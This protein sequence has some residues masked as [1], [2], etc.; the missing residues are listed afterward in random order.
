MKKR[1]I[2]AVLIVLFVFSLLPVTVYAQGENGIIGEEL[3]SIVSKTPHAQIDDGTNEGVPPDDQ[4]DSNTTDED[5][6]SENPASGDPASEDPASEDPV[7][8]DPASEDPASEDPVS[9]EPTKLSDLASQEEIQPLGFFYNN[10][11]TWDE[12]ET[13]LADPTTGS[14]T[15]TGDLTVP[16]DS[17]ITLNT[18]TLNIAAGAALRI[19]NGKISVGQYSNIQISGVLEIGSS[20]TEGPFVTG[21]IVLYNSSININADGTVS[22]FQNGRLSLKNSSHAYILGTLFNN[23][24]ID[25]DSATITLNSYGKYIQA[26]EECRIHRSVYGTVTGIDNKYCSNS[27]VYNVRT[28]EEFLTS[29]QDSPNN[30]ETPYTINLFASITLI[31]TLDLAENVDVNIIKTDAV[32][33]SDGEIVVSTGCQLNVNG[34][35][36][37]DG[38]KLD[39]RGGT[40][41]IK[42]GSI[43]ATA[44]VLDT[45]TYEIASDDRDD[46]KE[47]ISSKTEN[48]DKSR[49]E[50]ILEETHERDTSEGRASTVTAMQD[51]S[52]QGLEASDSSAQGWVEVWDGGALEVSNGGTCK[53]FAEATLHIIQEAGTPAG[54][55]TISGT[56]SKLINYGT[57]YVYGGTLRLQAPAVYEEDPSSSNYLII[58]EDGTI[59]GISSTY[60]QNNHNIP[61]SSFTELQSALVQA[62]IDSE[63]DNQYYITIVSNVQLAGNLTVPAYTTLQVSEANLTIPKA[64]TLNS[65]GWVA[66][67]NGYSIIVNGTLNVVDDASSSHYSIL[68]V[69][70]SGTLDVQSGG[71]VTID[72][73]RMYVD[74]YCNV[75]AGVRFLSPHT[76]S[77][78]LIIGGRITE[79]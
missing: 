79:R 40:L 78:T 18:I 47:A 66:V 1:I 16:D 26:D 33:N 72:L 23:G 29:L 34:G 10:I 55:V 9:V 30:Q 76:E 69:L 7:S 65:K 11:A 6:I 63:V 60:I 43:F 71:K 42:P 39:I 48:S 41:N 25:M 28:L 73:G 36:V 12:L 2:S 5:P 32:S 44:N 15:I 64:Y 8:E 51:I 37:L 52:S 53:L 14:L 68:Y 45:G 31:S 77:Y 27:K 75:L 54:L 17:A 58:N 3:P 4:I 57:I 70:D 19:P 13:A 20:F 24:D 74:G 61:V 56:G 38:G 46:I 35:I 59:Q 50:E 49:S 67:S 62:S 22:I 21:E